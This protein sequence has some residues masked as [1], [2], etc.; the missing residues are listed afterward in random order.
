MSI[1]GDR[2]I[3]NSC[4]ITWLQQIATYKKKHFIIIIFLVLNCEVETKAGTIYAILQD[5]NQKAFDSHAANL[6]PPRCLIQ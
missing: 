5:C 1:H 3:K 4:E 2:Q 6:S